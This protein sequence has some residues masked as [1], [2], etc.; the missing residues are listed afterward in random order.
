MRADEGEG[1]FTYRVCFESSQPRG[2]STRV[3]V[4]D[5]VPTCRFCV[6]GAVLS[7]FR[8]DPAY[9]TLRVATAVTSLWLPYETIASCIGST[10]PVCLLG[11]ISSRPFCCCSS[12]MLVLAGPP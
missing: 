9:K 4:R 8:R 1:G 10:L 5:E 11:Q 2:R 6:A 12:L 7:P 3:E